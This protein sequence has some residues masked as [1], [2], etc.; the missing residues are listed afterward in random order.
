MPISKFLAEVAANFP[1]SL[2]AHVGVVSGCVVW[3]S[4][5]AYADPHARIEPP[6]WWAG[7]SHGEVE[8][9]AH[10]ENIANSQVVI[11]GHE[12]VKLLRTETTNNPNYVFL[13]LKVP[14]RP[15]TV[16]IQFGGDFDQALQYEFRAR[17][18]SAKAG[19]GFDGSDL[20]Y[21][22][23][24]D[25]FAN[26]EPANDV[27][28]GMREIALERG[29]PYGRHGGDLA[30]IRRHLDYIEG[31]G[32]TQI[33]MNPV[34]ENDQI[35]SS[36]HGYAI[37]DHY[38]IDPRF[39]DLADMKALA[40][41][42]QERGIGFIWD[43]IPNHIGVHHWWLSDLPAKDWLNY[44]QM[45]TKT[46]HRRESVQDPYAIPSDQEGFQS[47][48]FVDAMP[49]LNQRNEHLARYLIQNTIWWIET[50]G[51]SGLRVDTYPY[52]DKTFLTQWNAALKA[53]YPDLNS[54]GEEWS[55][56]PAIIAYWQ[57]GKLNSD[58]YLG[59]SPSLMDF[60]LNQAVLKAVAE[61]EAWNT[62]LTRIYE[63][64]AS[65]FLYADPQNLVIFPDNHDMSRVF[66]QVGESIPSTKMAMVLFATL[67]GIPQ[68]FYGTEI[69]MHNRGTES[70]GVIRSDFPGGWQNDHVNA[71]TG[72]GISPERQDFLQ[73]FKRL[74]SWRKGQEVVH[75][76][77]FK[78]RAP[79]DGV[80]A[81]SRTLEGQSVLVILNNA[82]ESRE[83]SLSALQE[84]AAAPEWQNVFTAER[85]DSDASLRV[86]SKSFLIL[87]S[88][89]NS[90]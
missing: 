2:L 60:P 66:S 18:S 79:R 40:K 43:V 84:L 4:S 63:T 20:I 68:V 58:G 83:I 29:E 23:T 8:L 87:E 37:T 5:A 49:D 89:L 88:V 3:I 46:N 41:D 50:L 27:V 78:H 64:L 39:G 65:D 70:H 45:R 62:G 51:L 22:I 19:R 24:P 57:E 34:L 80:Y 33:W 30:G 86:E 15:V 85:I 38:A 32:V 47:G 55:M 54:V 16:D 59:S 44:P 17:D 26:G 25:R 10:G 6:N 12:S 67:R 82:N 56:N 77:A 71:F 72:Q 76:G 61:D 42:A 13:T 14:D 31:L 53:E 73:W 11:S 52:S 35:E 81:Y 90:L 48:W 21:L 1:R 75:S 69:L 36:Y 74:F 28:A 9:M 7:M